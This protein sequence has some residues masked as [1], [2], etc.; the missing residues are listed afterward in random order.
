[1]WNCIQQNPPP[2]KNLQKFSTYSTSCDM[3]YLLKLCVTTNIVLA[4]SSLN[5]W[6]DDMSTSISSTLHHI[7]QHQMTLHTMILLYTQHE[8]ISKDWSTNLRLIRFVYNNMYHNAIIKTSPFELV[9]GRKACTPLSSIKPDKIPLKYRDNE[10]P[11]SN[12]AKQLQDKLKTTFEHIHQHLKKCYEQN[13]SNDYFQLNAKVYIFNSCT[14]TC[15][16]PRKLQA[17]WIGPYT[18][19]KV[20]SKTRFDIVNDSTGQKYKNTHVSFL[21]P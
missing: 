14:S 16:N 8:T 9:H 4:R 3:V 15:N 13:T 2:H 18:V 11:E 7:I 21:K 19:I 5:R 12:F 6:H 1:M 20:H 17:D 10:T